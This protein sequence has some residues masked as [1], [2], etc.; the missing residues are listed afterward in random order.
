MLDLRMDARLYTSATN[1][2]EVA[3]LI[4]TV[5]V[6][7]H[8]HSSLFVAHRQ[9]A[10]LGSYVNAERGCERVLESGVFEQREQSVWMGMMLLLGLLEVAT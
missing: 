5:V 10:H 1:V 6:L 2:V 9:R 8:V 4:Q 3:V 7:V